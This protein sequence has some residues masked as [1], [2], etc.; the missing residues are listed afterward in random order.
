MNLDSVLDM[1]KVPG[2]TFLGN[3][4]FLRPACKAREKTLN[5]YKKPTNNQNHETTDFVLA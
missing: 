5:L 1:V 2:S 4:S 3:G